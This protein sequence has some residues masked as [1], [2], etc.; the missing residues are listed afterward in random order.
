MYRVKIFMKS[1]IGNV[2]RRTICTRVGGCRRLIRRYWRTVKNLLMCLWR[3][4]G[5]SQS[6]MEAEYFGRV[7]AAFCWHC[8]DC[9]RIGSYNGNLG[10]CVNRLFSANH[11][12][13]IA[14]RS[15]QPMS[16]LF[17][18]FISFVMIF[19]VI[20]MPFSWIDCQHARQL[21]HAVT[22]KYM[23]RSY[24]PGAAGGQGQ[25]DRQGV[26]QIEE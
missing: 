18:A 20:G 5:I 26:C 21:I 17:R 23:S 24:R 2:C 3:H 11:Q 10:N 9:E 19:A 12:Q 1:S 13:A 22:G 6:H 4:G 16:D 15:R 7:I 25:D 8:A 14:E